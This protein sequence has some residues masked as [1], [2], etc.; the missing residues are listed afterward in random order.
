MKV[1]RGFYVHIGLLVLSV[2]AAAFVWTRDKQP[3]TLAAGDVTVWSS[4]GDVERVVFESKTKTVTLEAKKDEIGRY[5]IATV[6]K[7]AAPPPPPKPEGDAGPHD[8]HD[9]DHADPGPQQ[10]TKTTFV[11]VDAGV[12]LA[13]ALASLKALRGLGRIGDDRAA[14]FG[15]NE[16]EATLTVKAGG[17][18]RKLLFGAA[19]PGGGDRYAR[20]PATGE[21]F[22]IK[23]EVFRNLDSAE[24]NLMERDLHEWKDTEVSSATV[25]A[26]GKSREVVRGG[27][28]GKRFW[29]DPANRDVNDE[30]VGNWMSKL[31][32]LRPT[33][34]VEVARE[35]V[36]PVARVEYVGSGGRKLG[37]IEL[38]KGPPDKAGKP[39]YLVITEQLRLYTKASSQLAEQVEQDI[40]SI[41]K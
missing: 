4:K 39:T 26:G 40:A 29:A 12:K 13:D 20:D 5:Y 11:S 28:E 33:E 27:P 37:Y 1:G 8:D 38:V 3:K 10:R 15:L 16:P 30:T 22:A 41:I 21:V 7:Q 36:E 34:Y 32:R 24:S 17:A 23:G 18:E 14:E 25:T 31:D 35:A 2:I 6:D 19:T 9:H